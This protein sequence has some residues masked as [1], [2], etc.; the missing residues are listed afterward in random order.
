MSLEGQEIERKS[1]RAITGK[2]ADWNE[3]AKDCVCFANSTGGKLLIGIE[4]GKTEPLAG[5]TIDTDLLDRL[6]K[7]IGELTVNV[8]PLP[9]IVTAD[10]GGE[11]IELLIQRS[12][13]VASTT[14]GRYYLRVADD[15]KPVLGD[16]IMRLANE[17]AALPWETLTTLQ[18]PRTQVDEAKFGKFCADIRASD[19]VKGSVKEK[20]SDELLDHYF[21][22]NGSWLTNLGVLCVG[23]RQDRA[24]LGT[25]PVIQF[26]KYDETHQK[27]DKL[28]WDDYSL[29]PMELIDA[30]WREVPAWRESYEIPDGLFRQNIPHYD[31]A[32]VRELLAN[33]LVHRPYTQRGDIFINLYPEYLEIVNPG[34]LPLGVTVH[35][36]LHM[37]V[38][39][40]EHLARLFHDLK[41]MEREGS[42]YD[43]IYEILL[44]QGKP[45]PE[46]VEGS[47]WFK[48]TVRK[49]IINPRIIDFVAKVD[50]QLQLRQREKI[51]LGLL[52]QHEAMTALELCSALEL[53]E[54]SELKPWLDRLLDLKIVKKRGKTKG[55]TYFIV[56]DVLHRL[57]FNI[58]TTLKNI[59]AHRLRELIIQDLSMHP[60]SRVGQIHERIGKEIPR[61]TL[62]AQLKTLVDEG[63]IEYEGEK[64]GRHYKCAK[65]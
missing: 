51:C 31:E 4:D 14:D 36:M 37:T 13:S 44:S 7:R 11:Y 21:F 1:L 42:G 19:R 57:D 46:P 58:E 20:T 62:Q 29:N 23:Q 50:S 52:A 27:V 8:V 60:S 48:V 30:V 43:K 26:L 64:R 5:Q 16:D 39:R 56:P 47:D 18:V 10:N 2:S 34:P 54:A 38:R 32:V 33:A 22:A 49:R 41:L 28:V 35:N 40:N 24:R 12:T 9:R 53:K 65:T 17:R 25:A 6:R 63:I 55:T 61:R 59:P 45:L 3:I 15:C